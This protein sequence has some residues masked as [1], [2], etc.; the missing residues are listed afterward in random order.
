[1]LGPEPKVRGPTLQK[2][3]NDKYKIYVKKNSMEK[4]RARSLKIEAQKELIEPHFH[5]SMKYK[6]NS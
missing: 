1:L 3:I 5:P 6:L 2:A 4:F